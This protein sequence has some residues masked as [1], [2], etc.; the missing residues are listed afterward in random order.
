MYDKKVIYILDEV[1][2]PLN[3]Y[4]RDKYETI[5]FS[6][7]V[8]WNGDVSKRIIS[9]YKLLENYTNHEIIYVAS[10]MGAFTIVP[11][12]NKF[13]EVISRVILLD[14][15]HTQWGNTYLDILNNNNLPITK[16]LEDFKS[17]FSRSNEASITGTKEMEN[18]KNLGDLNM[19]VIA[20]GSDSYAEFLPLGIQFKL[21]QSRHNL[22][23]LY[24]SLTTNGQF[25]ILD[26]AEHSIAAD[27]TQEVIKLILDM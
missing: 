14:P 6:P 27:Y 1:S 16:E 22:L 15:S 4:L 9:L 5:L 21:M 20:A 11:F 2:T 12:V 17:L 26:A 10:S 24:I 19:L 18:V 8:G 25:I 13:P 7:E 3:E 23:R